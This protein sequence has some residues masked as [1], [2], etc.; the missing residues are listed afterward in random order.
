MNAGEIG[1]KRAVF[2]SDLEQRIKEH[3]EGLERRDVPTSRRPHVVTPQRRDVGSTNL[4]VNKWQ[5]RDVVTSRRQRELSSH[6]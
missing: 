4:K 6:H 2:G 3:K 1:T 5:R